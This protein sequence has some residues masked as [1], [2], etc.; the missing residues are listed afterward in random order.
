MRHVSRFVQFRDWW[1]LRNAEMQLRQS[2]V[3]MNSSIGDDK[4]IVMLDY[5]VKNREKVVESVEE[6]QKFWNLSDCYIFRTKNGYHA[7]FW[8]DQI[9]YERLRMIVDYAKYV[10]PMYKYIS[11]F[12]AHKTIRVQGKYTVQDIA[13]EGIVP[14]QRDPSDD[15]WEIGEM[16]RKEHANLI[17]SKIDEEE[18]RAR[19]AVAKLD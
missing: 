6:L 4:H 8:F 2:A 17:G 18:R 3:G 13:F 9:P 5:D 15:E 16:K 14:G 10:D 7:F 1:K 11:R 12:Y 19:E